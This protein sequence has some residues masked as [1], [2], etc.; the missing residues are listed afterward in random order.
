MSYRD[1]SDPTFLA[2]LQPARASLVVITVT[3]T[4]AALRINDHPYTTCP[5]VS[6]IARARDLAASTRLL[7]AGGTHA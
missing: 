7:E 5:Q 2:V 4:D 6:I 1:L 3:A